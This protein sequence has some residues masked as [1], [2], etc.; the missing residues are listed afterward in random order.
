LDLD[1]QKY[2]QS[3]QLKFPIALTKENKGTH[4]K[5]QEVLRDEHDQ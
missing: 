4:E 2:W 1:Y 5:A 3:P